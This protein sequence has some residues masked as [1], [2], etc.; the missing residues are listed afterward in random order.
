TMR[1]VSSFL[2]QIQ[3]FNF[4]ILFSVVCCGLYGFTLVFQVKL[5]TLIWTFVCAFISGLGVTAGVHRYWCHRSYKATFSLRALLCFLQ[6]LA[7]QNSIL[8]WATNHRVHHK[9]SE[10]DA[11]PHNANRGF[12]FS[13]IG[14]IVMKEHPSV[15]EKRNIM[16][17]SDLLEDKVVA[18]QHRYYG[19]LVL[20]IGVMFPTLVPVLFWGESFTF[21][22]FLNMSRYC[23]LLNSVSMI[24]SVAHIWGYRPYDDTI[25]PAENSICA[26]AAMG[27]GY[28]NYHHVF[29][30]DYRTSEL[31]MKLNITASFIDMMEKL[32]LAYDLRTMSNEV[33]TERKRKNLLRKEQ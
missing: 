4:A 17:V 28:H 18:F 30:H 21:A 26:F 23:V 27:E 11:D 31:G 32:G 25:G 10:T 2:H 7:I 9:F 3:W 12:V 19:I 15:D 1:A 5:L 20:L 14:W 24:N 33:I 13:H 29:P 6:T 8:N 22:F 16:D